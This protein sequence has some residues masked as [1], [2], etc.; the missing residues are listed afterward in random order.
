MNFVGVDPGKSG[1]ICVLYENGQIELFETPVNGKDYDIPR[2][3]QLLKKIKNSNEKIYLVMERSTAMPGQ[4]SVSM[5]SFGMGF[6][7]WLGIINSLEISH[8]LIHPRTWTKYMLEGAPG[9]G[10]ERSFSVARRLFPKWNPRVSKKGNIPKIEKEK[11]DAI[12]LAEYA[13]RTHTNN[14]NI[15]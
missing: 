12:L 3:Y 4:G 15:S 6:G 2:M 10:K 8:A 11:A 14:S 5:F 9:E 7:I 1:N 13:R